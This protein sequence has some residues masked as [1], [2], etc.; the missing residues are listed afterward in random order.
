MNASLMDSV[1]MQPE[2]H[3]RAA[4]NHKISLYIQLTFAFWYLE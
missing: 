2:I 3:L 1:V 4:D